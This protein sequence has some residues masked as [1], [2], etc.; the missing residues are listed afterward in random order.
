MNAAAFAILKS[1][2]TERNSTGQRRAFDAIGR[3]GSKILR[4]LAANVTE[5]EALA[6]GGRAARL[7]Y[8]VKKWT[9]ADL[10]AIATCYVEVGNALEQSVAGRVQILQSLKEAGVQMTAEDVQQVYE[11]GRMES[12][13]QPAREESLLVEWENSEMMDGATPVVH[14][15]H[16]HL[17]HYPKHACLASQP[18]ALAEPSAMKALEQHLAWHYREFWGLPDGVDPKSDPQYFDRVRVMLGQQAPSAVGPPPPQAAGGPPQPQ[19]GGQ[20]PPSDSQG[21][22]PAL[23]P[24]KSPDAGEAPSPEIPSVLQ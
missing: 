23:Q 3:L 4:I 12:A 22:P 8:P 19:P 7:N 5:E 2:A 20:S 13:L 16:N 9:G 18:V 15:A 24:P 11:T 14:W 21:A 17:N 1:A 6:I 10:E